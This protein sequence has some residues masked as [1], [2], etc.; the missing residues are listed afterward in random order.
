MATL[1]QCQSNISGYTGVYGLS[2]NVW[3][4]EDACDGTTGSSDR[5]RLRGGGAKCVVISG[6]V[7][8]VSHDLELACGYDLRKTRS[9]PDY[10]LGDNF[11]GNV[12]F[13]CC[14]R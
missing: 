4:W 13:R 3:E 5:C 7:G 8:C 6:Y 12:G 10:E 2:G 1:T 11:F 9:I 14:S